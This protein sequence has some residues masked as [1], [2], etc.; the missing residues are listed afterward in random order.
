MGIGRGTTSIHDPPLGVFLD[1]PLERAE[2]I[3]QNMTRRNMETAVMAR[4]RRGQSGQGSEL[5]RART[6]GS[7]I[8]PKTFYAA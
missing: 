8:T 4:A 7:Q 5:A 6:F 2:L 1:P 3:N